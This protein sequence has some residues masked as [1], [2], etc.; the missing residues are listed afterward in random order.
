MTRIRLRLRTEA[1]ATPSS[2]AAGKEALKQVQGNSGLEFGVV[3]VY[4]TKLFFTR[5]V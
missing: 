3:V 1:E 5:V 2:C 4:N